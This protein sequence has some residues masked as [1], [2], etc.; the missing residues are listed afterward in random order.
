MHSN[1]QQVV[2]LAKC[3][4]FFMTEVPI[5]ETSALICRAN[6]WTSFYMIGVS[7]MK[8]LMTKSSQNSFKLA[9]S[10]TNHGTKR[11]IYGTKYSRMDQVKFV[12]D[13][14]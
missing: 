14:L 3:F 1:S 11:F 6:P 12:E 9:F 10:S 5:I 4:N 2:N 7:V 8:E 13:S